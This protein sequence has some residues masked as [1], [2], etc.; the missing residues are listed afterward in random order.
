MKD[1]QLEQ[2]AAYC[3]RVGANLDRFGFAEKRLALEGLAIQATIRDRTPEISG[4]IPIDMPDDV[5]SLIS[6]GSPH[7]WGR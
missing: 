7:R 6:P 4:S 3:A 1:V 2:V 5:E